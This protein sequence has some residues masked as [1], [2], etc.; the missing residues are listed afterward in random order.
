MNI[1][2][3]ASE[4][5][6]LAKSGGLADV[7]YSL[8]KEYRK[9]G[10]KVICVMPFYKSIDTCKYKV[11]HLGTYEVDVGWRRQEADL[12][13]V[14]IA[15]IDFY[16]IGDYY[17]FGRDGLYGYDDD[18]ERFAFFAIAARNLFGFIDFTPDIVHVH[19]WQAAII[20]CLLKEQSKNDPRFASTHTVLTIHN[21]AFKGML[22]PHFLGDFFNL[23][24]DLYEDGSVRFEDRFSTLKAGIYYADK[25][26]TVSPTHRAELLT[27]E[28]SQG[29]CSVLRFRKDDFTG[30]VNGVDEA[31]FNPRK[32]LFI[33]LQYG[34]KN[35]AEGKAAARASLIQKCGLKDNGGPVFGMVSRLTYQKGVDL[36]LSS[37][38]FSLSRG[39]MLFVLGSGEA[40]LE[41]G[42]EQLRQQFPE[43]VGIYIGY[44]AERAHEIYAASD[45]FL[46]PSLF[47]PCGIGQIIA[48][49][50]GAL[51][52]ARA[53]G[54]IVDTVIDYNG[55]NADVAT[56]ILFKDYDEGGLCYGMYQAEVLYHNEKAF[57]LMQH[58]AMKAKHS[59]K[60]SA[61]LYLGVYRELLARN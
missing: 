52:V 19:D 33:P 15:N 48:E 61:E 38:K 28:G 50:Y 47:E 25:I 3:V 4:I 35:M 55:E 36:L 49:A 22:D 42:L 54:G 39:A 10:N 2:M 58:N 26:T 5:N 60:D 18:G 23:P 44:S 12:Y 41:W 43:Q 17:Y 27:E 24:M 16:L 9:K 32:D 8:S 7:I 14:R 57:R 11:K 1:A 30:I 53:T 51:P 59:W 31:E 21:P 45:F 40:H 20:P 34:L 56:G 46:M 29:L 13:K 37:A 6:P